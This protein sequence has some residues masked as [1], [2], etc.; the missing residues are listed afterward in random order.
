MAQ[1]GR[2]LAWL[3]QVEQR[4]YGFGAD[5]YIGLSPQR[6]VWADSWG[7]FFVE[8]RLGYQ[9][10]RVKNAGI[11][12]HFQNILTQHQTKLTDFLNTHCPHPS[13]VHGDLWSGNVLFDA[14]HVWLIDPA[15]YHADREGDLAMTEMFG[16]FHP[17]FY[18]AYDE[19]YPLS[20]TYPQKK[21]IYNLYHYL[22]HYN[23]FGDSYLTGCQHGFEAIETL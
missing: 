7:V 15:V 4:Q 11:H 2:G 21:I 18:Q 16:G 17:A 6:N 22:N 12:A 14:K 3:H 10:G 23:L 20:P 9:V 19:T 8:Y 5:N 13:L 1:L